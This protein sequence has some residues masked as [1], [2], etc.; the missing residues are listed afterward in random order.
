MLKNLEGQRVP[1]VTFRTRN[2]AEWIDRSSDD[3][4]AGRTVVVFSLPR[5][6]YANLLVVPRP[7]VRSARHCISGKTASM[8]LS[9][10][11]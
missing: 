9:A 5:C 6:L 11:P 1:N 8:R 4:F 3:V 2:D 10:C 7:A